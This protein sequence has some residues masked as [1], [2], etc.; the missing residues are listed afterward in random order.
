M[1]LG[2]VRHLVRQTLQALDYLHNTCAV[3]HTG[4]WAGARRQCGMMAGWAGARQAA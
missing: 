1:P 2:V 3:I 4:G